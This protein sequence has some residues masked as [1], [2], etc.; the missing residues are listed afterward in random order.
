MADYELKRHDTYPPLKATLEEEN[1][2]PINLTGVVKVKFIAKATG[3]E[4]TGSCTGPAGGAFDKTGVVE[5]PWA[6]GDT[7]VAGS[8]KVEFEI[9]RSTSPLHVESVPNNGYKELLIEEDLEAA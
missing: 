1:G 4:I 3:A 7:K 9:E 8:Y 6:V 2:L 5:Y